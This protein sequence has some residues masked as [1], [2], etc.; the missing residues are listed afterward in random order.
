MSIQ[1]TTVLAAFLSLFLS[2]A[3]GCGCGKGSKTAD[4]GSRSTQKE[5]TLRLGN[6]NA[7]SAYS[8]IAEACGQ[9][10]VPVRQE[11]LQ[12]LIIIFPSTAL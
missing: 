9:K 8:Y 1:K 2:A 12:I 4:N 10:N 11:I 3:I 6:F 5:D 7:D